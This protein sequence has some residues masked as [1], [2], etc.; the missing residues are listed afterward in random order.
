VTDAD[1]AEVVAGTVKGGTGEEED[2]EE[3]RLSLAVPLAFTPRF[4]SNSG[5]ATMALIC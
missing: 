2:E 4:A 3:G 1:V 5:L